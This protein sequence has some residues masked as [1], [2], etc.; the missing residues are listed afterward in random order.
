MRLRPGDG[1]EVGHGDGNCEKR[2]VRETGCFV[3]TEEILLPWLSF[4]GVK[5]ERA[6]KPRD[7]PGLKGPMAVVSGLDPPPRIS[8][9][10]FKK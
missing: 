5:L 7:E 3:V 6:S 8:Y 4:E 1:H 10:D 9:S 2:E